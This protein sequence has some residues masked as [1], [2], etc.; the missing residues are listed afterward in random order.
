M[1]Y[2]KDWGQNPRSFFTLGGYMKH[3]I[4]RIVRFTKEK[5][6]KKKSKSEEPKEELSLIHI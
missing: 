5:K 3:I 2:Y 4:K 6:G 1:L